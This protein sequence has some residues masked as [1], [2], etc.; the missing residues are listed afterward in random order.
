MISEASNWTQRRIRGLQQTWQ[1]EVAQAIA[2]VQ[3]SNTQA[4]RDRLAA[5]TRTLD[6]I[7]HLDRNIDLAIRLTDAFDGF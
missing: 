2:L 3:R 4:N 6:I 1:R 5:A 7:D